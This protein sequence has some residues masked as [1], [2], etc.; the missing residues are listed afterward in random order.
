MRLGPGGGAYGGLIGNTKDAID[1]NSVGDEKL[2]S[3]NGKTKNSK[4]EE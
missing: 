3:R 2:R 4:Y 1:A